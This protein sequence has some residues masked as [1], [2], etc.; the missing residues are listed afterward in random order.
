M[1]DILLKKEI[2]NPVHYYIIGTLKDVSISYQSSVLYKM[3]NVEFENS[4][5]YQKF[6]AFVKTESSLKLI[7]SLLTDLGKCNRIIN[8]LFSHFL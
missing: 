8:T 4:M 7:S 3:V 1:A 5:K 2:L 6:K